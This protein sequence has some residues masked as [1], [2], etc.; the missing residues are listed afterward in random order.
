MRITS[1]FKDYYDNVQAQGVD[2]AVRFLRIPQVQS[3]GFPT[4]VAEAFDSMHSAMPRNWASENKVKAYPGLVWFCGQAY[5][6]VALEVLDESAPLTYF[7]SKESFKAACVSR[8]GR[9]TQ[10]SRDF[11]GGPS[12][13]DWWSFKLSAEQA[14]PLQLRDYV[15]FR[16]DARAPGQMERNPRLASL[17][18]QKVVA[19]TDAYQRLAGYLS[20]LAAP[21]PVMVELSDSSKALKHGFGPVSF[22]KR[23]A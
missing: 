4:G 9:S 11:R 2:Q 7:Y 16:M 17:G 5:P 14:A 1:P 13:E 22:R 12:L 21:E 20:S 23:A 19:P 3:S 15:C 10:P 18:F 8:I 6:Y